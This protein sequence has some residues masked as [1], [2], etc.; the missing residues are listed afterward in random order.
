MTWS[1][2]GA[3]SSGAVGPVFCLS[4]CLS[5]H[6]EHTTRGRGCSPTQINRCQVS[7]L[8]H[9][10]HFASGHYVTRYFHPGIPHDIRSFVVLVDLY[11]R[12]SS[13]L[14][15]RLQRINPVKHCD[16]TLGLS[17]Q[18]HLLSHYQGYYLNVLD[19][20]KFNYQFL[21]TFFV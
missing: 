14:S 5:T 19:I 11:L 9:S 7:P 16:L 1:S 13:D 20:K 17:I 12:I 10:I 15:I 18:E 2:V 4:V 21:D 6:L 8:R 3:D